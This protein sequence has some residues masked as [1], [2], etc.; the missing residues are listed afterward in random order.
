MEVELAPRTVEVYR[1]TLATFEPPD[2]ELEIEC[3]SG[4]YVRSI[5][6]D[7]GQCLGCG[8]VMSALVRTRVGP[9]R[10]ENAVEL[11]ALDVGD[12]AELLLPA[13]T[14]VARLAT[15]RAA[16]ADLERIRVGQPF[17]PSADLSIADGIPVAVLAPDGELACIAVV[18][19]E[20]QMLA[21]SHVF[22][23]QRT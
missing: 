10:I 6:R 1:L 18:D 9:Y 12:L 21:P 19:A 16:P 7:I 13:Q 4:T 14:A 15:C 2:F 8:A 3:G 17:A 22:V 11:E 5:G 20:R 23:T